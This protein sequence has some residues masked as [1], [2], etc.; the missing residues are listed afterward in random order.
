MNARN[1]SSPLFLLRPPLTGNKGFDSIME[2]RDGG[3]GE[4]KEQ[5]GKVKEEQKSGTLKVIQ[6]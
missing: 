2:T 5:E 6:I 1:D 3:R 4:Q